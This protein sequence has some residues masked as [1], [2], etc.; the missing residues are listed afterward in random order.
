MRSIRLRRKLLKATPRKRSSPMLDGLFSPFSPLST[1]ILPALCLENLFSMDGLMQILSCSRLKGDRNNRMQ[2]ERKMKEQ[3]IYQ[4]HTSL[5]LGDAHLSSFCPLQCL[6]VCYVTYTAR[7][8]L[9]PQESSR[10]QW[11]NWHGP[12]KIPFLKFF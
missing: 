1:Q 4:P 12:F 5:L 2:S 6:L 10:R 3:S 7:L 8:L 11:K 9:K